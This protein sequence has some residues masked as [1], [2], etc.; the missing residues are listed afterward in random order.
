MRNP[1][2]IH[3][4]WCFLLTQFRWPVTRKFYIKKIKKNIK[5]YGGKL[6]HYDDES[7]NQYSAWLKPLTKNKQKT[8]SFLK[9]NHCYFYN[10]IQQI[11]QQKIL[12]LYPCKHIQHNFIHPHLPSYFIFS[13]CFFV[14]EN[15]L[16]FPLQSIFRR[17]NPKTFDCYFFLIEQIA[18]TFEYKWKEFRITRHWKTKKGLLISQH[19]GLSDTNKAKVAFNKG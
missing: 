16:I 11:N 3:K 12:N 1:F 10:T 9:K 13:K 8:K 18:K 6:G 14:F 7:W 2:Y 4:K 5:Y 19:S 17:S 15:V